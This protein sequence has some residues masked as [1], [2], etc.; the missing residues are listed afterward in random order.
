MYFLRL[1][2]HEKSSP[3]S[4]NALISDL[5]VKAY[6][7]LDMKKGDHVFNYGIDAVKD[8]L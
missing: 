2:G 1:R 7:S 6:G 8:A 5:Y 3:L 4:G